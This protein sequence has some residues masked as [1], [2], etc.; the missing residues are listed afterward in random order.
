MMESSHLDFHSAFSA[1]LQ[2]SRYDI[3]EKRFLFN[4]GMFWF[5]KIHLKEIR[6]NYHY[7]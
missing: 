2:I 3:K 6:L 5:H 7:L 1:S 4:S